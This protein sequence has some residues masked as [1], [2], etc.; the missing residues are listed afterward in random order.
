M[1]DLEIPD[2]SVVLLVGAAG[3]GKSTFAARHFPRDA[4]LS[5]DAMR[6]AIAG[7][8]ADQSATRPAFAALH[9]SLDRR[10]ASGLLTVVDATNVTAPARRAILR[11]AARH[12]VPAIA[13][14]LDLPGEV[15]R[16]RNAARPDRVPDH[17]VV[18]H[19]GQLATTF[20]RAELAREGYATVIHLRSPAEV[21]RVRLRLAPGASRPRAPR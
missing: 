1:A 19:L 3:A 4:I 7:D 15:V 13:I 14:V 20:A 8:P 17:A 16:A 11:L 21:D 5:S 2:P 9:R 12:A 10:L 6:A 18:R